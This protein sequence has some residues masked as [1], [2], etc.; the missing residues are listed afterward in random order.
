MTSTALLPNP[1]PLVVLI[2]P[3][4][5]GKTALSVELAEEFGFEIISVDSM[6]VYKYMDIGTA[7]VT[8]KEMR[9][10][11]HHLI[12]VV[13]PDSPFDA[14]SYERLG[15]LAIK[16][17]QERGRRVLIT[18]GTGLYLKAL[19]SGLSAKIPAFP[20]IRKDLEQKLATAG[21]MVLHEELVACDRVSGERIHVNDH[22]RLVRALEI[23]QGTGR[24]WSS[25]I[26][27]QKDENVVRFS[28]ILQIG[29]TCDRSLLYSRIEQRT[30]IM[31]DSGF[32]KE[33]RD[34]LAQGYGPGLKSMQSIGYSHML[35][36]I[37]GE[38]SHS[39]MI[40]TLV[41]DTRRYAKRQYTWFNKVP[42]LKWFETVRK[43]QITTTVSNF[44]SR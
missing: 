43:K 40:E 22:H 29:L 28:N 24:P 39:K 35:R 13:E 27:Q 42:F 30:K 41:R 15:L 10:I 2:G 31:L 44:L 33:V 11:P 14:S 19:L 16:D 8:Q 3:T 21:P 34:L 5:I 25:F 38:W 32:E 17:I 23:F 4:A 26:Q 37:E 20:E 6:Q 1:E 12:N 36:Y 9:G 7:K 18:G